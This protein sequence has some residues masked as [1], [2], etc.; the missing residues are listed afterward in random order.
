MKEGKK[1]YSRMV[2]TVVQ[3]WVTGTK[4]GQYV[5]SPREEDKVRQKV[6]GEVS[7]VKAHK[8]P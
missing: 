2:P 4:G 6:S 1:I 7:R 8:D 5:R 3:R